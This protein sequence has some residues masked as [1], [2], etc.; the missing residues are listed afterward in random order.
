MAFMVPIT[1]MNLGHMH[2]KGH[3]CDLTRRLAAFRDYLMEF[4]E[5]PQ[6]RSMITVTCLLV[7]DVL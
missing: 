5:N 6:L 7:Y 2:N 4:W 1:Q 3:A